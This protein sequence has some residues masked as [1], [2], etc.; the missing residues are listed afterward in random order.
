MLG[1]FDLRFTQNL[2]KVTNAKRR[3]RQQMQDAQPRLIAE[4][5]V[6]LDEIGHETF[7]S[8]SR[9]SSMKLLPRFVPAPNTVSAYFRGSAPDARQPALQSQWDTA[10]RRSNRIQL[11]HPTDHSAIP[12]HPNPKSY[13]TVRN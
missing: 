4:A 2:L 5:L 1:D 3:T 7:S 10:L 8:S 6:D 11:Q 12:D 13:R 9:L